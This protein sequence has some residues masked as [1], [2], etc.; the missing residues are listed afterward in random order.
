MRGATVEIL[1][2]GCEC[3]LARCDGNCGVVECPGCEDVSCDGNCYCKLMDKLTAEFE[4][5]AVLEAQ[6][7]E[8]EE[9]DRVLEMIR[10]GERD[11]NTDWVE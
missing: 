9:S 8:F 4:L 6:A 1:R 3:G 7:C 5:E 11:Y 2:A 10:I